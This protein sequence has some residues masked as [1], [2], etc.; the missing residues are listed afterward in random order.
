MIVY[1][2]EI[3]VLTVNTNYCILQQNMVHEVQE[4]AQEICY[5]LTTRYSQ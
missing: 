4:N 2:Q 5:D 3:T 1:D